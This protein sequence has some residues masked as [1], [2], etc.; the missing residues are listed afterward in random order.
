MGE[1]RSHFRPEFLNRVDDVV[2]FKPL[3]LEEIKRIV[4]L[5]VEDIRRRLS[6]R[7]ICL[8]LSDEAAGFIAEAGFDPVYGAR[9]LKRFL[10][11]EVE[12]RI[13]REIIA[14]DVGEGAVIVLD[15]E[16]DRLTV[17]ARPPKE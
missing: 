17:R 15:V 4:L 14:G 8:E 16:D 9:P 11:H 5:M 10:Q 12:T 13:G 1:L 6:D 3:V 2:L 7:N